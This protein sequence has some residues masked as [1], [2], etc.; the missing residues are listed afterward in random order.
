MKFIDFYDAWWYLQ[1]HNYFLDHEALELYNIKL[2]IFPSKL[3]IDVQKVNPLT[4]LID[5]DESKNTHIE[6]W[7]ECGDYKKEE[8]SDFYEYY[9]D[10]KL[11][12]G[13]AT[14]EEAIIKL[15]NLVEKYYPIRRWGKI[16][17]EE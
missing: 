3:D 16:E 13:G 10:T 2:S 5:D 9:H 4:G 7:L 6:V 8:N 12:C 15:A 17:E 1:N 14:F 11:D